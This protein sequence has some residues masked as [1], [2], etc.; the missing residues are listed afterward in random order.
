MENAIARMATRLLS[1]SLAI[2][3]YMHVR[4]VMTFKII[5]CWS[6]APQPSAV[7]LKPK[8]KIHIVSKDIVYDCHRKWNFEP[9]RPALRHR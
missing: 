8:W 7:L 5:Q 9:R 1:F 4:C 3:L 6:L 2:R